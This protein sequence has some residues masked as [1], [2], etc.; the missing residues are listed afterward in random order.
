VAAAFTHNDHQQL[1]TLEYAKSGAPDL[2]SLKYDYTTTAVP[3]NN[4]QIQVMHYCTGSP[5]TCTDD[6]T[7]TE[8]FTYDAWSRLSAAQTTNTTA[9]GTWGLGWAYDR[10]GNRWQQFVTAGSAPSPSVSFD[11]NTNRIVTSGYGYDAAGNMTNDSLHTYAF[12]AENR[13]TQVDGGTTAANTYLGALRVK[14]VAGST[15]TVYVYS[16]SKPIAEYVGGTLSK[17]YIYGG[18][19]LLATI[20]GSTVTYEHPDHLSIRAESDSSGN[21]IR[22]YGH[23]P[24]GETWYENP[25]SPAG[26]WDFTSYERDSESGLD[27]AQFRYDSSRL[28][29]FMSPDPMG[30][31][32]TD[33]QSLNRY[34]YTR[35]DPV[36]LTD[37]SG[38]DWCAMWLVLGLGHADTGEWVSVTS[39]TCVQWVSDF[40]GSGGGGKG[41]DWAKINAKVWSIYYGHD[42]ASWL[43]GV[44]RKALRDAAARPGS[45]ETPD[46]VAGFINSLSGEDAFANALGA[47]Q[48]TE[49]PD[50]NYTDPQGTED[51]GIVATT[52]WS[53][54]GVH[55]DYWKS[56]Y[57]KST[58]EQAQTTL[59]EG[60]H[61]VNPILDDFALAA[62][63]GKPADT[64]AQSSMNFE[65]ELEK[66]CK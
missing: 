9:A 31:S 63:V 19:G 25:S 59:H 21:L 66:H 65:H 26:K 39:V 38:M 51:P 55:S 36:N 33:P 23:F 1:A 61:G 58:L 13:I 8:Q 12:D 2:L 30:G 60:T 29:R 35:N 50:S 48:L 28:G 64:R 62:A 56:F 41:A 14:K 45:G 32:T 40:S 11:Q 49:H 7:K 22:S 46:Q 42:C 3:G 20:A 17:E 18:S 16:G 43:T 53:A 57:D 6:A 44:I 47:V 54:T 10:L 5:A 37:P 27:Y 34:T 52:S 4:G 15:T 24:F